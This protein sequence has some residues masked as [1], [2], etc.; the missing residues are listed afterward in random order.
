MSVGLY[1]V[2]SFDKL[3]TNGVGGRHL[4]RNGNQK[5]VNFVTPEKAGVQCFNMTGFRPDRRSA[6]PEPV[7]GPEWR[8]DLAVMCRTHLC[9]ICT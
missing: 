4:Q 9:T 6:C 7:E 8:I 2:P 1:A 5:N 3:R